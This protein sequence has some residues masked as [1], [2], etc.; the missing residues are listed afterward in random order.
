M[1]VRVQRTTL[2]VA[3]LERAL[4]L[5]RDVLG[6]TVAFVKDSDSASYSYPAFAIPPGARIRFATLDAGLV[7]RAL[8]LTEVQGALLPRPTGIRPAALVL[9]TRGLK[10]LLRRI[11]STLP[12]V[13]VLPAGELVTHDGRRGIEVALWDEDGHVIVLY[14]IVPPSPQEA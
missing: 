5:Y 12:A 6:F 7:P 9:E 10:E 14:E 13:R 8:G 4:R 1:S 3:D 11:E 2:L